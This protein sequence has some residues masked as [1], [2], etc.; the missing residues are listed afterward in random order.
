MDVALILLSDNYFKYIY[1][2]EQQ[3]TM[4]ILRQF[5]SVLFTTTIL[6][7]AGCATP[8]ETVVVRDPPQKV[9]FVT[10]GMGSLFGAGEE[11]I[12]ESNILI[13]SNDEWAGLKKKMDAV[14][15]VTQNFKE[16]EVNFN[17][18]YLIACFDAT[19]PTGGF[20]LEI[21]DVSTTL[22]RLEV[23]I[24]RQTPKG[25]ATSVLSQPYHIIRIPLTDKEILFRTLK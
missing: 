1:G 5:K 13:R 12:E 24:E 15:S 20:S 4:S 25:E 11:G 14:N 9:E 8:K 16:H 10:I 3:N 6:F 18:Y 2:K 17:E 7:I 21:K 23:L 19:R 22:K